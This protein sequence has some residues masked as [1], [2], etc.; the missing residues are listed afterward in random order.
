MF[1]IAICDDNKENCQQI[2]E[3]IQK[4]S[5]LKNEIL[6]VEVFYS[7]IS[8]FD[9]IK[10]EGSFD[11]VFLDIE[12]ADMNGIEVGHG[13]R[14]HLKNELVKIVYISGKE[15]YAMDLFEVRPL[16]FLIKPIREDFLF[17]V[18][19]KAIEINNKYEE[20]F[21]FE[22]R[23]TNYKVPQNQI[24]YNSSRG[25]KIELKEADNTVREFYGKLSEITNKLTENFIRIHKS[26]LVNKHYITKY[27]SE[28]VKMVNGETFNISRGYKREIIDMI[29]KE[30]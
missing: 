3:H 28:Q 21:E 22:S 18:I 30:D 14:N 16:N 1:R 26:Y 23:K 24:M 13:I 5:K 7:G 19:D 25:R 4:Y 6:E 8:F 15:Q 20:V 9:A 17:K 27:S 10:T 12:M 11:L 2:N 29:M